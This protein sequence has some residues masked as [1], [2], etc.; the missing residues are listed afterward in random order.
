M[1]D[2]TL[3]ARK[4]NKENSA[5]LI[6]QAYERWSQGLRSA[7]QFKKEFQLYSAYDKACLTYVPYL[8]TA[9]RECNTIYS[10]LETHCVK[11]LCMIK[12]KHEKDVCLSIY[13]TSHAHPDTVLLFG[14][15]GTY[16][17]T[18]I[19]RRKKKFFRF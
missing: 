4:V 17:E 1:Y 16:F 15:C 14:P 10:T 13:G 19:F 11:R 7:P 2:K 8:Q 5:K 9:W 18:N 3:F 6:K 12:P